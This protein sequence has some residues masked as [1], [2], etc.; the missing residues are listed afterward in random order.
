MVFVCQTCQLSFDNYGINE[1]PRCGN[2]GIRIYD[3]DKYF[4]CMICNNAYYRDY[5]G[6]VCCTCNKMIIDNN[7]K[8]TLDYLKY[9]LLL[10]IN[11]IYNCEGKENKRF[12]IRLVYELSKKIYSIRTFFK[13]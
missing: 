6:K 3:K 10:K 11:L 7:V 5:E 13:I 12:Q 8:S 4:I 9:D 2:Y 1:C